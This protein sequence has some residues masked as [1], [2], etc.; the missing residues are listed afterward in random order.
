MG[1]Q[2]WRFKQPLSCWKEELPNGWV[3]VRQ[4]AIYVYSQF[5]D[6]NDTP[7]GVSDNPG[8][9][10]EGPLNVYKIDSERFDELCELFDALTDL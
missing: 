4:S 1:I 3:V 6:I 7:I 5:T 10:F 2:R 8:I 9:P